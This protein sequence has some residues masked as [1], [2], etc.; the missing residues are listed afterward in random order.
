MASGPDDQGA[1]SLEYDHFARLAAL[2]RRADGPVESWFAEWLEKEIAAQMIRAWSPVLFPGLL[3]TGD[4]ARALFM[5]A[6]AGDSRPAA[7]AA[8]RGGVR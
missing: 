5:A 2:A 8:F 6:A 4:Y 7:T 3:Q 1:C